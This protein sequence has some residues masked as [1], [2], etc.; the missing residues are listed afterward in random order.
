M[1]QPLLNTLQQ[2]GNQQGMARLAQL[3]MLWWLFEMA[4]ECE[5]LISTGCWSDDRILLSIHHQNPCAGGE[6]LGQ[7]TGGNQLVKI[8]GK[9]LSALR[10]E[11]LLHGAMRQAIGVAGLFEETCAT[12]QFL[13]LRRSPCAFL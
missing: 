4:F 7:A 8:V 10:R 11:P 5:Q 9:P 13:L 3:P 1:V 6:S 2:I 12:W